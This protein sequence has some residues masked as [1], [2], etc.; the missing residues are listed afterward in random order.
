MRSACIKS[1]PNLTQKE[2]GGTDKKV[3]KSNSAKKTD[4]ST[5]ENGSGGM[6]S[7]MEVQNWHGTNFTY[8][9]SNE[10]K[11]NNLV[12]NMQRLPLLSGFGKSIIEEEWKQ[13]KFLSV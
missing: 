8:Q 11:A 1:I 3:C 4:F 2:I 9:F 6:R 5:R 12:Q 10:K 7:N 13:L